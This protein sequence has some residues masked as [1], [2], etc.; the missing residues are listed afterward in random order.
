MCILLMAPKFKIKS[1]HINMNIILNNEFEHVITDNNLPE[2][3]Q[4]YRM[5]VAT[6]VPAN[7]FEHSELVFDTVYHFTAEDT[8]DYSEPP[9]KQLYNVDAQG[10]GMVTVFR[11]PVA[12]AQQFMVRVGAMFQAM[13][14][15]QT[16]AF[17][18]QPTPLH[19][20]TS[21]NVAVYIKRFG[22]EVW[23]FAI[24]AALNY[25]DFAALNPEPSPLDLIDLMEEELQMVCLTNHDRV[26]RLFGDEN[27]DSS[28][29]GW[30]RY[31]APALHQQ[32]AL[33]NV[34]EEMPTEDEDGAT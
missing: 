32:L 14:E 25:E 6:D 30:L 27:S 1:L 3:R 4:L 20:Q 21:G 9:S 2:K 33:L 15:D 31:A 17:L 23:A 26:L 24:D 5:L 12:Y 16:P 22:E 11:L 7:L 34:V 19:Y 13:C 10:Y 18:G 28:F 29:V 8:T